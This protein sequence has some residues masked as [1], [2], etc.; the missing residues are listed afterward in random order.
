[1]KVNTFL[2]FA[3]AFAVGVVAPANAQGWN[4]LNW[5]IGG[6]F[7]EPVYA[8][9]SSNNVGWNAG[10]G[11]GVSPIPYL[12]VMGDFNFNRMNL[13]DS[14]LAAN[15]TPGGN[16]NIWSFSVDPMI[17]LNP[18]GR[19]G[20]Y[21]IGGVGVYHRNVQFTSPTVA[22]TP[23]FDPF[24]G[25]YVPFSFSANVVTDE[26]TQTKL[27]WDG[28]AGVEWKLGE[29][30]TS[31]YAEARYHRMNSTPVI[32]EYVPVTFGFRW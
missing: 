10:A 1:M 17:R 12:G 27:G 29:G 30:R 31:F 6:G 8:T 24:F 18:R 26:F 4:I 20:M 11:I 14:T 9:G 5:N 7:T 19:F 16:M 22:T 23:I 3:T 28:G 25:G 21:L 32:T 15:G 2:F 13:N